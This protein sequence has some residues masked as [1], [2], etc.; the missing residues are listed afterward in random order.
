MTPSS[1]SPAAEP[2]QQAMTLLL[3]VEAALEDE[4]RILLQRDTRA[5][6]TSTRRKSELLGRLAT[7]S[8]QCFSG[9]EA[10][11]R[12]ARCRQLNIRNGALLAARAQARM[13]ALAGIAE[14]PTA[15]DRRGGAQVISLRRNSLGLA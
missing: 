14:A 8:A 2:Q 6:P 3:A 5:L 13:R 7:L 15:Y 9:D 4:H 11:T 10:R 1:H 12:L